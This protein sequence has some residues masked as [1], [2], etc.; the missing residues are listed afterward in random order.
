MARAAV[1]GVALLFLVAP[2]SGF[3]FRLQGKQRLCFAEELKGVMEIVNIRYTVKHAVHHQGG[4]SGIASMDAAR[5]A[6][7]LTISATDPLGKQVLDRTTYL[8]DGGTSFKT[9]A[10]F[11][12]TYTICIQ[13]V[14]PDAT[15]VD[16]GLTIDHRDRPRVNQAMPDRIKVGKG[17]NGMQVYT[18]TDSDGLPK[19]R[20]RTQEEL[21]R[22]HQG[23]Q[24]IRSE[25]N[26]IRADQAAFRKRQQRFG[27]TTLS[28]HIRVWALSLTTIFAVVFVFL[29]QYRHIKSFLLAK[30]LV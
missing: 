16:V 7:P 9:E 29:M 2:V 15:K 21:A 11:G 5:D 18:Y 3:W 8:E 13:S 24:D 14:L 6:K 23:L 27:E 10:G 20:L 22:F 19:E 17:P 28:T 12:G 25:M 30:K 26:D 1:L 4:N